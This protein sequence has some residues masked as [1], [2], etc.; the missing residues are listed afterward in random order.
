V[1]FSGIAASLLR[2]GRTL[3][4]MFKL[5]LNI[6]ASSYS[7]VENK[8]KEAD[9]IK[10]TDV[11]IWDEAPMASRH[12]MN[13]INKKLQEL[14]KNKLPF[15]G[16]TFILSGDFRQT[17]PIKKNATRTEIVD[18]TIKNCPLWS[19]FATSKLSLN[20]R[21][22]IKEKDFAKNLLDI[23]DGKTDQEGFAAVPDSV[24]SS[25]DLVEEIYGDIFRNNNFSSLADRA[26]L[27]TLNTTVD[28]YNQNVVASFPGDFHD[29][30]FSIDETNPDNKFSVSL[31]ILNKLSSSGLSDH[32]L[33]VKK[34]C[35]LIL[36]RNLNLNAG[37]CNGTRLQ[38]LTPMKNLLH[39]MITNGDKKGDIVFIPRI[40]LVEDKK[41]SFV[42]KRHQFP[43][44]LA[45]SYSINKSQSQTFEKIGIDL[46]TDVF[47]HGQLYVALSRV[48]S[49]DGIKIKLAA[50]NTEKKV[51]NIVWQE[52]L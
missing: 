44:K 36:L 5:P 31:D 12:I 40:T 16:K 20:M 51:K 4:N 29:T 47:S 27:A 26:I 17:L 19:L 52:V 49:W 46:E 21:A 8:G 1:A 28:F 9:L 48:R 24:F 42:L 43:V 34:D 7:S 22:G 41:F 14:M 18:L 10:N 2:K 11:F 25:G 3:H 30:Y 6:T 15:G 38:L 39:C 32:E 35:P 13:I 37:L 45:F 50:D 23:G 33:K